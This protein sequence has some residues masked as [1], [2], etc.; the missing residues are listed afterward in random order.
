MTKSVVWMKRTDWR[1]L[2][3]MCIGAELSLIT[4][5]VGLFVSGLLRDLEVR[6]VLAFVLMFGLLLLFV[7]AFCMS[8]Y[9]LEERRK[10]SSL[11]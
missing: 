5:T 6:I 1:S 2:V 3:H 10:G 8:M 9:F 4:V 7:W 11:K